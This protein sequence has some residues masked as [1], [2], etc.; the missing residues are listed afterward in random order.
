[1]AE[2]NRYNNMDIY[3]QR[4]MQAQERQVLAA[5]RALRLAQREADIARR[6]L[7]ERRVDVVAATQ[8]LAQLRDEMHTLRA[9]AP[10]HWAPREVIPRHVAARAQPAPGSLRPRPRPQPQAQNHH[11]NNAAGE[12]NAGPIAGPSQ[13]PPPRPQPPSPSISASHSFLLFL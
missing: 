13:P 5:E 8:R 10:Q 11:D 3:G 12:E 1:M 7:A 2:M 6:T 9:R 4:T